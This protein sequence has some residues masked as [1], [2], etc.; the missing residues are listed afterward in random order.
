MTVELGSELYVPRLEQTLP[1]VH[2]DE[3][4]NA[5]IQHRALGHRQFLPSRNLDRDVRVH[6]RFERQP[7]VGK[8]EPD[9]YRPALGVEKGVNE[10]DAALQRLSSIVG[11][12]D[13]GR[14]ADL[15][16]RHFVLIDLGLDPDGGNV[17]DPVQGH[18]R[19]DVHLLHGVF[20]DDDPRGWRLDGE[21]GLGLSGPGQLEDLL[22]GN[23]PQEQAPP[24]GL[25]QGLRP[26]NSV[27]ETAVL[28]LL[29]GPNGEQVFLLGGDKL[30]A[31]KSQ[32][33]L[34]PFDRLARIV[35]QEL[36]NPPSD[37]EVDVGD[38]GLVVGHLAYRPNGL[39]QGQVIHLGS[40][41]TDKLLLRD[42]QLDWRVGGPILRIGARFRGG[43]RGGGC[44]CPR[45]G[46]IPVELR[47]MASWDQE[48][49][50]A[51]HRKDE[52]NP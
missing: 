31:I 43:I 20:Q 50:P 26:S 4:P 32:K 21:V 22:L 13:Y 17:G 35:H 49:G 27:R 19:F 16:E 34:A 44:N 30:R 18:A 23:V 29:A 9:L 1:L 5:R 42:V 6:L 3:L 2:E 40:L 24:A 10:G 39:L 37:L 47:P 33:G 38:F 25:D 48:E 11:E 14:L 41:N 28:D 46:E 8:S 12:S 51:H 36:F 52:E 7:R 15:D 45:E